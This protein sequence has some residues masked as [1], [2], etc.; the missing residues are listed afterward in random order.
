MVCAKNSNLGLAN[1]RESAISSL[2]IACKINVKQKRRDMTPQ[3]LAH[4]YNQ[5]KNLNKSVCDEFS[6]LAQ[7]V[8]KCTTLK[9]SNVMFI[10]K[11]RYWGSS[12][13]A[14]L[15]CV[16]LLMRKCDWLKTGLNVPIS[17]DRRRSHR[18]S[19]NQNLTWKQNREKEVCEFRTVRGRWHCVCSEHTIYI[20]ISA[21]L[22]FKASIDSDFYILALPAF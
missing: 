14:E 18:I 11:K 1:C 21:Y 13:I 22:W 16:V 12:I 7:I 3:C 8:F 15:A 20:Y 4:T 5:Q 2:P 19:F 6:N 9:K 17:D 10:Y